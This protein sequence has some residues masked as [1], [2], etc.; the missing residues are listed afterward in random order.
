MGLHSL[1]YHSLPH[2]LRKVGIDIS[3]T[4]LH[5][6]EYA[7]IVLQTLWNLNEVHRK[8]WKK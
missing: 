3:G 8:L 2:L 7:A 6:F 5:P 4:I 1:N